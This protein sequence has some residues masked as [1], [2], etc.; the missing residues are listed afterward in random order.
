MLKP[1]S[2]FV[3]EMCIEAGVRLGYHRAHKH[4]DNPDEGTVCSKIEQAIWEEIH[5]WFDIEDTKNV[6]E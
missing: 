3:L 4:T 6:V 2:L 1:K 5:Q